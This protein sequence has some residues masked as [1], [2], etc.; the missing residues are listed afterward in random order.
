MAN[1]VDPEQMLHSVV[2]DLGLY[3]L[4]RPVRPQYLGLL[5]YFIL[6]EFILVQFIDSLLSTIMLNWRKKQTISPC[7]IIIILHAG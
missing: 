5:W 1:N 2:S 6:E 3:C 7:S 4:S